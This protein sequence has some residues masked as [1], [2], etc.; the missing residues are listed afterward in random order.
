[1]HVLA[2]FW[3]EIAGL[4]AAFFAG[5]TGILSKAIGTRMSAIATNTARCTVAA[6]IFSLALLAGGD[7]PLFDWHSLFW[8]ALSVLFSIVLGDTFFFLAIRHIG[9]SR[10]TPIAKAYP[11]F[12]VVLGFVLVGEP[13]SAVKMAGVATAVCGTILL[14]GKAGTAVGAVAH[15]RS[16]HWRGVMLAIAT[17]M[18]WSLGLI[19]IKLALTT[20]TAWQ[21]NVARMYL[22]VAFLWPLAWHGGVFPTREQLRER[23]TAVFLVAIGVCLAGSTLCLVL[24]VSKIGAGSAAVYSSMA[25]LFAVP[26]SAIIFGE[27]LSTRVILGALLSMAGVIGIT[28]ARDY[29]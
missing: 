4:G 20:W 22:A 27:T 1:M 15:D 13:L 5:F 11:A 12:T 24:A 7:A 26:L 9:V 6:C 14:S 29:S 2:T 17:A 19:A 3:G 18:S 16:G 8:I 10:A 28:L 25:P 21:T 23:S